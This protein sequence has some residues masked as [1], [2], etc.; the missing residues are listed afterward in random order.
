[1]VQRFLE[2]EKLGRMS[3]RAM[4]DSAFTSVVFFAIFFAIFFAEVAL[5]RDVFWRRG[6]GG[7]TTGMLCSGILA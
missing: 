6:G 3:M 2:T 5:G 4:G 7:A 1:M